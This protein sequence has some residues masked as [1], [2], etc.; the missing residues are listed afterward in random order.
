MADEQAAT[1]ACI[2][3]FFLRSSL[4]SQHKLDCFN[5]IQQLYPGKAII[6]TKSQGYC[7]LTLFV[8]ED[9]VIQFR[10]LKYRLDLQITAAAEGIYGS[11]VPATKYI[12]TLPTSGLLVYSMTRVEGLSLKDLR[13]E[14]IPSTAQNADLCRDFARF[15]SKAWHHS[16]DSPPLGKVGRSIRRRLGQ[17]GAQLPPR[18]RGTAQNVLRELSR[19]DNLPWVLTHGDIVPSNLLVFPSTGR[20]SGLV[21]WAEAEYLPFGVSLYGLEEILGEMT[22]AGFKYYPEADNMR[23]IFWTELRSHVPE[24]EENSSMV[25][26]IKLSRDLGVLLWYG[27]AFDDGAI[28]RVVQEGRDVDE[29]SKLETFLNI[30]EHDS[31]ARYSKI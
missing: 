8:G 10:P 19:I 15:L 1:L 21:D 27:I 25:D 31:L 20:L 17:L 26:V 6:P 30:H 3:G 18:F 24:L 16:T 5:F 22:A 11:F 14:C 4:T 7:S 23:E 9:I 2:D 29:I 28:D 12:A 13:G